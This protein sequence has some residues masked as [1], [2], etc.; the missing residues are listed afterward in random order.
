M[1]EPNSQ[2]RETTLVGAYSLAAIGALLICVG[3]LLVILAPGDGQTGM[4]TFPLW[5]LGALLGM[6]SVVLCLGVKAV[7]MEWLIIAIC[8]FVSIGSVVASFG[9]CY[10]YESDW[11]KRHSLLDDRSVGPDLWAMNVVRRSNERG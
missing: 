10:A 11:K 2:S 9:A 1:K 3:S 4:T 5:A 7:Q 6:V 8:A